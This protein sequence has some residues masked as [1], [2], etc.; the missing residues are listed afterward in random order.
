MSNI[1]TKLDPAD[2]MA[3]A[4]VSET[5]KLIEAQARSS[6]HCQK[7]SVMFL[8]RFAGLVLYKTLTEEPS[9]KSDTKEKQLKEVLARF[10][11]VKLSVQE[12]VAASFTSAM[13]TYTGQSVE[14]YCQVKPVGPALNKEPI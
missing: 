11:S 13:T 7:L 6:Q 14:Y 4:L 5:Y 2:Q 8:A 12:A 10:G 9:S 3:Q 1:S